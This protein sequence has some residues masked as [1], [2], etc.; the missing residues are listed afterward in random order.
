MGT[1]SRTFY[2]ICRNLIEMFC[3]QH[4]VVELVKVAHV[5]LSRSTRVNVGASI[6]REPNVMS[7]SDCAIAEHASPSKF[8]ISGN[9]CFPVE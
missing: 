8:Q 7:L 5:T 4:Y 2:V 9:K 3:D 1:H 6:R